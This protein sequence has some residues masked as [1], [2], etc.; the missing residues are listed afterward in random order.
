MYTYIW[1]NSFKRESMN[2][3]ESTKGYARGFGGRKRKE[4]MLKMYNLKSK[5]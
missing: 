3:K 5:I 2:L 4:E 1:S